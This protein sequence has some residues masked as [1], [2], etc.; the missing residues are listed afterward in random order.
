MGDLT[1]GAVDSVSSGRVFSNLAAASNDPPQ[2]SVEAWTAAMTTASNNR[3]AADQGQSNGV[4][5]PAADKTKAP[6]HTGGGSWLDRGL[7]ILQAGA[8][9]LETVGGVVGGVLT[10]ETGIGAVAGGV[11]AAHGLDDI[12]AGARQAWT[13]KPTT[14]FT[15]Q[16]V[17]AGAR[18]AGVPPQAAVVI[19]MGVDIIAGGGVG[20][21]E[22]A[23][24]KGTEEA[25]TVGR[26]LAS[27]SWDIKVTSFCSLRSQTCPIHR[28]FSSSKAR[29]QTGYSCTSR[30]G[31]SRVWLM[32]SRPSS[33]CARLPKS[34]AEFRSRPPRLGSE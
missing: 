28:S 32:R 13:G 3:S 12:Q 10:S 4:N 14:T 22:K 27:C 16:A 33:P 5:T 9:V 17:T 6:D 8:G 2:S 1:I 18:Q 21:A 24:V 31:F 34:C 19:G 11:V 29:S 20:G 7:G 26:D 15:Q 25:I 30:R 23:A